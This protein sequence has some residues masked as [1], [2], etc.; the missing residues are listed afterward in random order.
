M[1]DVCH[2]MRITPAYNQLGIDLKCALLEL[3]PGVLLVCYPNRGV[4]RRAGRRSEL[5]CAINASRPL[6]AAFRNPHSKKNNKPNDAFRQKV[7]RCIW[8]R[9]KLLRSKA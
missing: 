6:F 8:E 1:G 5:L 4:I 7:A 2:T 3:T 9:H